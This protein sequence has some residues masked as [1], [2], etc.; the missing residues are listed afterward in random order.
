MSVHAPY[1]DLKSQEAIEAFETDT[2]RDHCSIQS[3]YELI[4]LSAKE[5]GDEPAIKFLLQ[6]E[7][8]E[9]AFTQSYNQLLGKIT[10]TANLFHSLG[11]TKNDVV[12]FTLPNLPET[13]HV[14]W[15]GE[16]AGIVNPINPFLEPDTIVKLL[17]A[18]NSK[19]LV[20]CAPLP[21]L[22]LLTPLVK[23]ADSLPN[24]EA[25]LVVDCAPYAGLG[26]TPIPGATPGGL[27]ITH[28]QGS[29]RRTT[30]ERP[31]LGPRDPWQRYRFAISYRRDDRCAQ[32]RT[33]HTRE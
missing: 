8:D 21:G 2:W 24:L 10:Q 17:H 13:H 25:I 28:F 16:A 31:C 15:G 4:E 19:I 6:G 9:S 12:S 22:D 5:F 33:P 14:I 29:A 30:S 26:T 20:T 1:P 18:A 3:T 27:P 32:T 23:L 11:V 7:P